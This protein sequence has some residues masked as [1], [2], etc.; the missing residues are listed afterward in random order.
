LG[1]RLPELLAAEAAECGLACIAMV[2]R[3][4]G[5]DVDLNGLRQRFPI[6]LAGATLRGLM[7]MGDA[8]GFSTRALRVEM[9]A[10]KHVHLPAIIHWDFNH[11]VVLKSI[12]KMQ[13]V[14]HD[15]ARGKRILSLKQ[16]SN[17][18]TGV[19]LELSRSKSF[20][21]ATEAVPIHL[22]SLWSRVHGFWSGAVQ[23]LLL[24]IV[25][26]V[27]A[28]AAPFQ[29][30]LVVDQAL[31]GSDTQL[32]TVIALGFGLLLIFQSVTE[33][34][35][36]WTLQ[37]LGF[38]MSYQMVGNL[39]HHLLRLP[40]TYFERRHVGD[41]LSRIGSSAAIQDFLTRG[42]LSVIIDG[43][44]A[45]VAVAI[46]LVYSPTLT[47]IVIASLVLNLLVALAFYPAM[48][49][50]LQEKLFAS[51]REQ[52]HL[53]ESVRAATTIKLMGREVER[54]SN[55]RNLY[56][57]VINASLASGQLSV[58]AG[59]LQ[60]IIGGVQSIVII[61]IAANMVL[62]AKGF[63]VGMLIALLSYR[64]M[65]TDRTGALINQLIQFRLLRLHLERLSDIVAAEPETLDEAAYDT[66]VLGA[67]KLQNVSFRYGMTDP[68]ILKD[69][70]LDI[71]PRDFIAITGASG[72]GKTSLLKLML[73]LLQPTS[74][75]ILLDGAPATPDRWRAWRRRVGVVAQDDRLLSGSIADNISFFDP[76]MS[77]EAV[78]RAAQAAHV[79]EDIM[80]KPMQYRSLI[81]DMGST[82]SGGQRQ[83]ILLARALYRDPVI[84]ILD[85]GTANLDERTE[86]A[87]A[88]LVENLPI[89][90]IVVAHR[91]ALVQ[92]ARRVAILDHQGL[93]FTVGHALEIE[94]AL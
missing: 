93:R 8:L 3:Y 51:A 63:S 53:M 75:E 52:S 28:L 72:G 7:S 85:E 18:Y 16:L 77:I 33:A 69:I 37:A 24:S 5:H 57:N 48:R 58:T 81:G 60:A 47:A 74:G 62:E 56:G 78:Q 17:H 91:P 80:R 21:K 9:E 83:R 68:L 1:R 87:I 41:I 65:L 59:L 27:G 73:G 90:R 38:M 43:V 49:S 23:L 54:E 14:V 25:L 13:A 46:L 89:T 84:L 86:D 30:Q 70:D 32:L 79:H 45:S 44:M 15:P 42:V 20:R 71:L 61:Y 92:R 64:Q 22:T 55:W 35:R 66:E 11:F 40:A 29:M 10:L 36:G 39:V 31:A 50:R 34:L 82:L 4:H 67:I 26:Q 12:N 88:V 6:S 2:G 94:G 76:E 19:A